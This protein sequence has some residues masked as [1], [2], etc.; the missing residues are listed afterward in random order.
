[1]AVISVK[2]AENVVAKTS[3]NNLFEQACLVS[4]FY[5]IFSPDEIMEMPQKR[6]KT[7]LKVAMRQKATDHKNALQIALVPLAS[8]PNSAATKLDSF[9]QGIINA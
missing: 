5:P 1:M 7:M 9:Y 6:V 4:L 3:V 8:N 2:Q